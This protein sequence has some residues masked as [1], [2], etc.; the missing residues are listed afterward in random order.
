MFKKVLIAED[1]D[2]INLAVM[3]ALNEIGVAEV[4]RQ[5]L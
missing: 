1:F 4:S 3:Q 5:I 2:S